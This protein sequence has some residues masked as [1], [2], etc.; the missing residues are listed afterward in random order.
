PTARRVSSIASRLPGTTSLRFAFPG[1]QRM[2]A[3]QANALLHGETYVTP[4]RVQQMVIPVMA[5][6]MLLSSQ[7]TTDTSILQEILEQVP[8]PA[9][10]ND[11]AHQTAQP[12]HD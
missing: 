12:M 2:K 3:A 5:H 7:S 8:V 6:R 11:A 10:P 9:M 1:W 4:L